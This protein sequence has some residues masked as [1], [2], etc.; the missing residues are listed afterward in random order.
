MLWVNQLENFFH[1]PNRINPSIQAAVPQQRGIID[2][3]EQLV[4]KAIDKAQSDLDQITGLVTDLTSKVK[5]EAGNIIAAA[6]S[7]IASAIDSAEDVVA[8]VIVKGL[9]FALCA[10]GSI[11]DLN[12]LKSTFSKNTE[13]C[14][15][16]LSS[17]IE[18]FEST[19]TTDI[20]DLKSSISELV[21]IIDEC[22]TS[23]LKA[24]TCAIGKVYYFDTESKT[25]ISK[26]NFLYRSPLSK[27]LFQVSLVMP[28]L[29]S[30]KLNKRPQQRSIK[31]NPV[32][33]K[34]LVMP[35]L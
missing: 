29:P 28:N 3:V 26:I 13:D 20:S 33:K 5:T 31:S 9:S 24:I 11:D 1:K 17:S 12:N 32:P 7:Q 15:G 14:A 35:S 34:L 10:K 4:N 27:H 8:G 22:G 25:K 19:V 16:T 23:P 2:D 6:K 30:K 18:T 21:V